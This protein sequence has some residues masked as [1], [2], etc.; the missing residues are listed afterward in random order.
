MIAMTLDEYQEL[1]ARTLGRDRTH[2]QQ[3]ANA[4]LGLT[5]EAGEVAEVIKKHLFHATPL[6]QDAL[7]KELGDCLW[8]I[9]AFATV[10]GLSMDDIAQRNIDKLR[11]RYPEGFDTERSRNRT[12]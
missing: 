12:E 3:L 10:L 9:G 4:A 2:D 5:G 8:Y 6:D 1:A 11:K 7:A